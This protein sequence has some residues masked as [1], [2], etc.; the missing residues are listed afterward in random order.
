MPFESFKWKGPTKGGRSRALPVPTS[1]GATGTPRTLPQRPRPSVHK[2]GGPAAVLVLASRWGA[3]AG[4]SPALVRADSLRSGHQSC[5]AGRVRADRSKFGG[6]RPYRRRLPWMYDSGREDPSI[7][8]AAERWPLRA[9]TWRR[10]IR[11]R[12]PARPSTGVSAPSPEPPADGARRRRHR[13]RGGSRGV[14]AGSGTDDPRWQRRLNHC[15]PIS[16]R[17]STASP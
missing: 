2:F 10:P 11:L 8:A 12:P 5:L 9:A 7:C 13:A 14:S 17:P 15:L 3:Q 1:G 6:A 4:S 16:Q